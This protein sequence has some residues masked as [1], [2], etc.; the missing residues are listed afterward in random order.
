MTKKNIRKLSQVRLVCFKDIVL[1]IIADG[2]L[3]LKR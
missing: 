3:I 1:K 2:G